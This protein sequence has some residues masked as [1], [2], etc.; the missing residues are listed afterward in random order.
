MVKNV[1]EIKV[2][3]DMDGTINLGQQLLP[4]DKR[5]YRLSAVE[6]AAVLFL[7]NNSSERCSPLKKCT[8]RLGISCDADNVLTSGDTCNHQLSY[9]A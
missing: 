6:W 8:R 7:T 3:L 2:L 4:G 9:R 5:V 1:G